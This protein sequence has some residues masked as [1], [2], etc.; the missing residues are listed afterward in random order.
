[1]ARLRTAGGSA[2]SEALSPSPSLSG[3]DGGTFDSGE[4]SQL[5][6][7]MGSQQSQLSSSGS[8]GSDKTGGS[9]EENVVAVRGAGQFIGEMA[10]FRPKHGE[11]R[12][13][14]SVR[15]KN[16]VTA[17]VV[18]KAQ[19]DEIISNEPLVRER[20]NS[21]IL[22]RTNEMTVFKTR[23]RLS[24]EAGEQPSTPRKS[25]VKQRGGKEAEDA[26]GEGTIAKTD[27][28]T[29]ESIHLRNTS[30]KWATAENAG[31]ADD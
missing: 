6:S 2:A 5:G 27:S 25:R 24:G 18:T 17:L 8:S 13:T 28:T 16:T 19:A 12:R 4:A 21:E 22:K 20:I 10:L 7:R 15:A 26:E 29:D 31:A 14:A 9:N 30:K 3:C 11:N 23:R 1:M